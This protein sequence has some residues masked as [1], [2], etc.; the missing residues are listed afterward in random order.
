[1]EKSI[2]GLEDRRNKMR[3]MLNKDIP[4]A[5]MHSPLKGYPHKT[6]KHMEVGGI[7]PFHWFDWYCKKMLVGE[8]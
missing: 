8:M 3:E 5:G 1:M 7:M 6:L 4:E 2:G